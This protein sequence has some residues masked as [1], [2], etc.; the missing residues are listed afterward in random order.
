M[1]LS[2]AASRKTKAL[3]RSESGT[4]RDVDSEEVALVT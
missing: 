1:Q 3:S 2:V 4:G